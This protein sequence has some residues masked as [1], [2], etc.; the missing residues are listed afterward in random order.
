MAG[1][2]VVGAG[3]LDGEESEEERSPV[4]RPST[5]VVDAREDVLGGV[6]VLGRDQESND[7]GHETVEGQL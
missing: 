7:N 5:L 4:G 3:P 2:V 6:L 1:G